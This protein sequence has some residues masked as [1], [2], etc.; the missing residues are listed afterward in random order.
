MNRT[1]PGFLAV[2]AM[3]ASLSA[4][5]QL[6]SVDHGAAATDSHGLMWANTVGTNLSWS[7]TGAAGSVQAWVAG[8]NASDY[9]GYNNWTLATGN[10]SVA[11]NRTTNQLGELFYADCGNSP[12]TSSV[13]T[14]TGKN[15]TALSA[16]NTVINTNTNG[17]TNGGIF[18]SS[19][20]YGTNCCDPNNTYWWSY[21]TTNGNEQAWNHDSQF[22]FIV[23]LGDALAVRAAPEIDPA[24]AASGLTLLLGALAVL[25]G[26]RGSA[27]KALAR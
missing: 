22:G 24:S 27:A 8:L 1:I 18:F 21:L 25:R 13:L 23:G 4:H 26:R 2:A 11:A 7:P 10:G 9:G 14:H 6:T 5:A 12:G 19:S 17:V 15:C 16:V 3:T 20:L